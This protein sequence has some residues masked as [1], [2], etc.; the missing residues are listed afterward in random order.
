MRALSNLSAR[1]GSGE[2][3]VQ[4]KLVRTVASTIESSARRAVVDNIFDRGETSEVRVA[5]RRDFFRCGWAVKREARDE[6]FK[7]QPG[8]LGIKQQNALQAESR[9]R[10]AH[11]KR[12]DQI[13][14]QQGDLAP[15]EARG[16]SE[17]VQRVVGGKAAAHGRD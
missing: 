12:R 16:E 11:L 6:K 17:R 1:Y 13:G 3:I 2:G 8:H 10:P 4:K 5:Q 9:G 14:A 7:Q 15:S